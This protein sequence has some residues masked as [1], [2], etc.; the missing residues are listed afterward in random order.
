M[1]SNKFSRMDICRWKKSLSRKNLVLDKSL[2]SAGITFL[3]MN[4]ACSFGKLTKCSC[5]FPIWRSE[6][7]RVIAVLPSTISFHSILKTKLLRKTEILT[8]SSKRKGFCSSYISESSTILG[9]KKKRSVLHFDGLFTS[10]GQSFSSYWWNSNH[11]YLRALPSG[12]NLKQ[13]FD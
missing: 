2:L 9:K 4:W 7:L 10:I 1:R 6:N 12:V 11:F 13:M 5:F 8:S 3:R